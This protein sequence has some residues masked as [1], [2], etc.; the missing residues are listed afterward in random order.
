MARSLDIPEA[1]VAVDFFDD[2]NGF[3]FHVRVLLVPAGAGK[4][5]WATPDHSVQF[6][7]LAEHRVVPIPRN[8]PFPRRLAG[9]LYVFDPFNDGELEGIRE[10][11]AAL[12]RVLGIEVS[13][14]AAGAPPRWVV[15]DQA[16]PQFGQVIDA[17]I[18]GA[19][20]RFVRRGAV[21]LAVLDAD[22]D[23]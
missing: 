12:A 21:A 2:P 7:D 11:A 8:A 13:R 23:E 10:Q 4:W 14:G 9:Q 3:F 6:G 19:E 20:D 1:Q 22:D 5:I 15:A 18:S 17:A 16:H